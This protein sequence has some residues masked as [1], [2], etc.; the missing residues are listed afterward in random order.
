MKRRFISTV[1]VFILIIFSASNVH[2]ENSALAANLF[3]LGNQAY[4]AGNYDS[5]VMCYQKI[6][7][8]GTR[9]A[10]VYYNLGNALFRQNRLGYAILYYEKGLSLSPNDEDI[11]ANLKYA[12][13]SI[14]DKPPEPQVGFFSKVF[15]TAYGF[16]N[17]KQTTVLASVLFAL[18]CIL[19]ISGLFSGYNG[20]LISIYFGVFL[21]ICLLAAGTSLAFKINDYENV[22]HAIVLS[23]IVDALNEPN[24]T[25]T[26]FSVHEGTKFRIEKRLNDWVLVSLPNGM[27][28]WVQVKDL[29]E[30]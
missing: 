30:I 6:I 8:N 14:M 22:R 20:R 26:L 17:L 11:A 23:P 16:L 19:A 28:G 9:N 1:V 5:A 18:I 29:G 25:Q 2:A 15:L 12:S 4:E 13:A 7:T 27:A 10:A 3:R 21:S 24:G